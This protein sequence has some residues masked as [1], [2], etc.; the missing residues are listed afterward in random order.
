M[1]SLEGTAET[2]K[3]PVVDCHAHV[4]PDAM[5]RRVVASIGSFYGGIEVHCSGTATDLLE[6]GKRAGIDLFLISSVA[7]RPEQVVPINRFVA[8][9]QREHAAVSAFGTLHPALSS[10]ELDQEIEEMVGLGLRGVK[11]HPD[12]QATAIDDPRMIA[13]FHRLEGRLPVLV[14]TGDTRTR[15]SRPSLLAPIARRFP[16]LCIIAAHLGGVSIWEEPAEALTGLQNLLFDTSSSLFLLPPARAVSLIRGFGTDKVLFGTDYPMWDPA[17]ELDR[18]DRLP[19]L[20]EEREDILWRNACR[21][22]RLVI[23]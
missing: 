1:D 6:R 12:F 5:A 18:F 14:H 16:G 10:A 7:T 9:L 8:A 17:E 13:I 15:Y 11:L 4:F 22:F 21:T 19:L 3:I 20:P 2:A 23:D